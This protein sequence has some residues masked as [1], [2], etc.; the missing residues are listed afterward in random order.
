MMHSF[1]A[2][3]FAETTHKFIPT[4]ATLFDGIPGKLLRLLVHDAPPQSDRHGQK[5]PVILLRI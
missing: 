4:K 1:A 3:N 2:G 5:D